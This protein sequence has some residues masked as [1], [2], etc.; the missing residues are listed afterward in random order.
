MRRL[1][2][3]IKTDYTLGYV[4]EVDGAIPA[5]P[6]FQSLRKSDCTLEGAQDEITSDVK[7]PDNRIPNESDIGTVS[8]KGDITTEFNADEQDDFIAAS[9]LNTWKTNAA[10]TGSGYEAD[11]AHPV[12]ATALKVKSGTGTILSG[13]TV[14][15]GGNSYV[16]AGD[17]SAAGYVPLTSPITAAIADEAGVTIAANTNA[18]V[19]TLGTTRRLFALVKKYYQ[20]P[21][22]Y[23]L[24][25][26]IQISQYKVEHSRKSHVK[27]TFSVMGADWKD[28]SQSLPVAGMTVANPLTTKAYTTLEGSIRIGDTYAEL[29][30]NRQVTDVDCTINNNMETTDAL[31]ETEA[32]ESSLGDLVISGNIGVWNSD[33]MDYY[34]DAKAGAYKYITVTN[35]RTY[36][37]K[38][39]TYILILYVKLKAPSESKDGNKYKYTIPFQMYSTDGI[40]MIKITETV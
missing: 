9:F 29:V 15:V 11:G 20:T 3:A 40:R 37:G 12:G 23:Q 2:N 13:N 16:C 24:F 10:G 36:N 6:I 34:N 26:G 25:S 19:L 30:Q 31:Y 39:T 1:A 27:Q 33:N 7:L 8:N 35:S 28:K 14:T 22:E 32:I 5:T 17:I 18:K 4:E 38:K 21:V